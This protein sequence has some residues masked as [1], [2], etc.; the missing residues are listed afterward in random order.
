MKKGKTKNMDRKFIK[1]EIEL[2]NKFNFFNN[3][4]Y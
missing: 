3:K 2:K 1:E 4:I